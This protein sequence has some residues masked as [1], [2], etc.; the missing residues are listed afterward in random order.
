[1]RESVFM[2]ELTPYGKDLKCQLVKLGM[3]QKELAGKVGTSKQYLGKI[4]FGERAGTM[5]LDSIEQE[6]LSSQK[7]A[8]K[9]TLTPYG[10]KVKCRLIELNMTQVELAERVG[11]TKQYLGKILHGKRS[12]AMYIESINQTL[13]LGKETLKVVETKKSEMNDKLF[14]TRKATGIS[15]PA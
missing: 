12:G 8:K 13:G 2:R 11:T 4:L 10:Q 5:Y 9:V 3:T 1:V 14:I 15:I 6:M 7:I